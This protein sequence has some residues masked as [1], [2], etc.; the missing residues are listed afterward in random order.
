MPEDDG[1]RN[2]PIHEAAFSR[3]D[4]NESELDEDERGE[5]EREEDVRDQSNTLDHMSGT[6][7]GVA[8]DTGNEV[9]TF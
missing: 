4:E 9:L 2:V 3:D 8:R 7:E 1:L 5:D 6:E